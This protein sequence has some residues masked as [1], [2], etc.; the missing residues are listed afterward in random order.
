MTRD[1]GARAQLTAR[2]LLG[3]CILAIGL[4]LAMH[5][6]LPLHLGRDIAQDLGDPLVQAGQIA[7]DGHALAHQPLRL[8]QANT[9]WPLPDSLAFSDALVGYA[10]FGLIGSGTHAAV[11]PRPPAPGAAGPPCDGG[12]DAV[13]RA[14]G[15]TARAPVPA[16][17]A[18]P[19]RSAADAR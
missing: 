12:R 16:R 2:E 7:W 13:L 1:P 5:W 19:S 6:P 15:R 3:C 17:P 18:R 4:A 14:R 10:P 9:F 8:F 11:A